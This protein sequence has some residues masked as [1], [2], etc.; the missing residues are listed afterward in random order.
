MAK[1]QLAPRNFTPTVPV[2]AAP[3]DQAAAM[4]PGRAIEGVGQEIRRSAEMLSKIAGDVQN[5]VNKGILASEETTRMETAAAIDKYM[6][7]N[8]ADPESWTKFREDTIESYK[9]ERQTRMEKNSWGRDVTS[10]DSIAN[11]EFWTRAEISFNAKTNQGMVRYSN[12]RL[13]ANAD[14]HLRANNRKGFIKAINE[15]DLTEEQRL[16]MLS[17]GLEEGMYNIA[18]NQMDALEEETLANQITGYEAFIDN[19]T[20]KEDGRFVEYEESD[21]NGDPIGGMSLGGRTRLQSIANARL[22]QAEKQVASNGR[23]LLRELT[24]GRATLFDVEEAVA[25]GEIS[26]EVVDMLQPDLDAA[27]QYAKD[28]AAQELLEEGVANTRRADTDRNAAIKGTI[29]EE[30]IQAKVMA[31]QYTQ[32]QGDTIIA[33]MNARTQLQRTDEKSDYSKIYHKIY[34][35]YTAKMINDRSAKILGSKNG[36]MP[37]WARQPSDDDYRKILENIKEADI[38]KE[39]RIELV[40]AFLALR[41]SDLEDLEEEGTGW[42]GDRKFTEQEKG[43]RMDF[44]D[45]VALNLGAL[46]PVAAG[47]LMLATD[48]EIRQ[49]FMGK[50]KASAGEI[51]EYMNGLKQRVEGLAADSLFEDFGL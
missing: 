10:A 6:Q 49:W 25:A 17:E 51:T 12:A 2:G 36:I 37:N 34:N 28:V 9:Q 21:E 7:D 30:E 39:N 13:K 15:M 31:G 41:S 32:E 14:A 3:I 19:I 35:D 46:G 22:R 5:Q 45:T 27:E 29:G 40:Q 11:D 38:T 1:I 50:P 8:P 23:M 16:K 4:A 20:A 43:A 44:I 42:F 33:Q 18:S 24:A 26:Q 47:E 48:L